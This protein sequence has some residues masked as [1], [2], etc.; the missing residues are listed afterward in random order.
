MEE[1]KE[2]ETNLEQQEQKAELQEME[3]RKEDDITNEQEEQK[4][5]LH[6]LKE[7]K[8]EITSP[9]EDLLH[10]MNNENELNTFLSII[11]LMIDKQSILLEDEG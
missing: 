4:G 3:E 8:Q 2:D 1:S 10:N 5:E 11:K 9:K 6:E 7:Q